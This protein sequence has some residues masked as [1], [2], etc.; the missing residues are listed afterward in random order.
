M[1]AG[2]LLHEHA[3]DDQA[4]S[5][6]TG[7]I[8]ATSTQHAAPLSEAEVADQV[9]AAASAAALAPA[10]C[11][12]AH[13]AEIVS[14]KWTLLV[15]RDLATGPKFFSD[16]ERSLAGISPRT[17]C[18]R[19]KLLAERGFVTRTRIK[20]VPPRSVYELTERGV[21]LAPMIETMRRVGEVLLASPLDT[22][23]AA[24]IA[25]EDCCG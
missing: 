10:Q 25:A 23:A 24:E 12:V 20:G 8:V 14:G 1:T 21:E 18:E 3:R 13:C 17:L 9:A 22:V 4:R 2:G 7:A 19:L 16:L 15:I 6:Y 11:A 5:V